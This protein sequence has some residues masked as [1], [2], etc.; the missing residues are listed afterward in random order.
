MDEHY[1]PEKCCVCEKEIK[2]GEGRYRLFGNVYCI[3]HGETKPGINS[4]K[5]YELLTGSHHL[6]D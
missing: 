6:F 5:A 2:R 3:Q 1:H 4:G